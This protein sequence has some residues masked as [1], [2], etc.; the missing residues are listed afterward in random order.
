MLAVGECVQC[1]LASWWECEAKEYTNVEQKEAKRRRGWVVSGKKIKMKLMLYYMRSFGIRHSVRNT[2]TLWTSS[3]I[4]HVIFIRK[5]KCANR[6]ETFVQE[7]DFS[8]RSAVLCAVYMR[9]EYGH[10]VRKRVYTLVHTQARSTCRGIQWMCTVY[11]IKRKIQFNSEIGAS[12][13][14]RSKWW[15]PNK[16]WHYITISEQMS[17]WQSYF[18]LCSVGVRTRAHDA[19]KQPSDGDNLLL[20]DACMPFLP[21]YILFTRCRPKTESNM[22]ASSVSLFLSAFFQLPDTFWSARRLEN[23]VIRTGW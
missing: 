16:T 6:K 19:K 22:T 13:R 17:V 23:W 10:N 4:L 2:K 7:V 15:K 12:E 21:E 14:G 18:A 1:L 9:A 8:N 20:F 5:R 11:H 3:N